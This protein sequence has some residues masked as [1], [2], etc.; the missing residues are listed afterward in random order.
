MMLFVAAWR[1]LEI[2]IVS[3]VNQKEKDKDHM[4]SLVP[5]I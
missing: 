2:I 4:I 1:Y 5:G 3:E